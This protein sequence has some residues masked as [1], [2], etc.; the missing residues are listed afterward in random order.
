MSDM[1]VPLPMFAK[2]GLALPAPTSAIVSSNGE[3]CGVT[4]LVVVPLATVCSE[5]D[6]SVAVVTYG[7]FTLCRSF[8]V[9]LFLAV[10]QRQENVKI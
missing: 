5:V 4:L 6:P 8:D 3:D 10:K 2:L 7:V 9:W 1:L